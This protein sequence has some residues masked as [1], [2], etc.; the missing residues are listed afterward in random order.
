MSA[1]S[2]TSVIDTDRDGY[3]EELFES[4]DGMITRWVVDANEDGVAEYNTRFASGEPTEV[5]VNS[6]EQNVRF[7]YDVYPFARTISFVQP[8]GEVVLI[9]QPWS[10][11]FR[12]A[13]EIDPGGAS[14]TTPLQLPQRLPLPDLPAYYRAATR[15]D[16]TDSGGR[17]VESRFYEAETLVRSSHD[18]DDDGV[19]DRL[20]VYSNGLP[21]TVVRDIDRDGYFEV[22]E[23]YTDGRLDAVVVDDDDDGAPDVYERRSDGGVREWDLNEDGTIDVIEYGTL[24]EG[25]RREFPF[26]E[27]GR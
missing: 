11:S 8:D 16:R 7:E 21:Q 15:I 4:E 6:G 22:V 12:V 10:V 3:W 20:V 5:T 17:V 24:V 2:G 14:F 1:Y 13:S 18:T 25:V 27:A 9:P 26:V 19:F 23:T